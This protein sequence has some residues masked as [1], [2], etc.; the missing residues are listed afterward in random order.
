MIWSTWVFM[1]ATALALLVASFIVA[2]VNENVLAEGIH[3]QVR[4]PD[5]TVIY[6]CETTHKFRYLKRE[7]T[8]GGKTLKGYAGACYET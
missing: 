6:G 7:M 4:T 3:V 2:K 1:K 8:K 5:M